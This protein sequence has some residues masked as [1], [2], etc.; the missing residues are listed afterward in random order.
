MAENGRAHYSGVSSCL[1][2]IILLQTCWT[3]AEELKWDENGYILYCP[4]MGNA[5]L[6]AHTR[7]QTGNTALVVGKLTSFPGQVLYDFMF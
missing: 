3:F 1:L 6:V 2:L 7:K 4:C 5:I